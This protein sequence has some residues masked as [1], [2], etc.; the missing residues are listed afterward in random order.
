MLHAKYKNTLRVSESP[1]TMQVPG[2]FFFRATR[3]V[4]TSM[5][6]DLDHLPNHS[7]AVDP[8]NSESI[9]NKFRTAF[10]ISHSHTLT[11]KTADM[12]QN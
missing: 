9:V 2:S 7:A 5:A 4:V 11:H 3:N 12:K 6:C 10:S 1:E 8:H